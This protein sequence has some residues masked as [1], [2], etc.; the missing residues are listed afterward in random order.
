MGGRASGSPLRGTL[1]VGA[2]RWLARRTPHAHDDCLT[3]RAHGDRLT[4]RAH[5]DCLTPRAQGDRLTLI[6]LV[7]WLDSPGTA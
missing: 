3:P 7:A 2:S 5:D 1:A 4:T 6:A